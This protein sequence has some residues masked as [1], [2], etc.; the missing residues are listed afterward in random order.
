MFEHILVP[1]D[2][3]ARAERAIPVAAR[4]ACA[5]GGTIVL[6]RV[7]GLPTAFVPYPSADPWTIQKIIDAGVAEAKGY[8]EDVASLSSLA[9]VQVETEVIVGPA[10]TTILSVA[11]AERFDLI[12]LCSHR[13]SGMRR[14]L[15]GSVAEHVAR[16]APVPV[17]LLRE[18]G[19][20][21]VGPPPH[22]EGPLRALIPLDGSARAE[23]AIAPATRL[24]AALST[25]GPAALHLTQVIGQ[26][27]PSESGQ[28]KWAAQMREAKRYLS[29]TVQRLREEFVEGSLATSKLA[30]TWS[31]ICDDD[32]ATGILRVAETGE[33]TE[34][35]GGSGNSDV[36]AMATHGYSGIRRWAMGSITERVLHASRL[37]LLIVR[38]AEMLEQS[39][40]VQEQA[41]M[42]AVTQ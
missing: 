25:P 19:P 20:T 27:E 11:Q 9:G 24:I 6:L 1:L 34:E 12:V 18:G 22:A 31:V 30:I 26:L 15:L 13:Y 36:I 39:R 4:L 28:R 17:L 33:A 23:T 2:G 7:A 35:V 41:S 40:P 8:I 10:A 16:S 38:P 5:S 42:A 14:W 3:S 21:L 32:I 29:T 37:P